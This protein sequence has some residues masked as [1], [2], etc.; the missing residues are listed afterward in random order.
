MTTLAACRVGTTYALASDRKL[1]SNDSAFSAVPKS[2]RVTS[3]LA[4]AGAG[5]GEIYGWLRAL[6]V[7]DAPADASGAIIV[8]DRIAD[9]FRSFAKERRIEGAAMLGITPWGIVMLHCEGS[10]SIY[11]DDTYAVGSGSAYALGAMQ[12]LNSR[13][14]AARGAYEQARRAVFV[15]SRYDQYTGGEIDVLTIEA[16]P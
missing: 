5:R 16:A 15:A 6:T 11:S 8:L 7:D 12:G 3:W 4:L 9:D 10:A 1:N 13:D 14:L 2:R